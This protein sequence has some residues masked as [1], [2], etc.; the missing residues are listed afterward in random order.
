MQR[1]DFCLSPRSTKAAQTI[2]RRRLSWM[3]PQQQEK[4]NAI[5]ISAEAMAVAEEISIRIERD[6]GV[7]LLIDYG[8]NGPY[9]MSLNAIKRHAAIHVLEV[10]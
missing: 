9:E 6:N 8:Q 3:S 4:T 5:E 1:F 2:L 10:R 7:A